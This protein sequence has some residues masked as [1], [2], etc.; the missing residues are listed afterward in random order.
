MSAIKQGIA[1]LQAGLKK[2]EAEI[3]MAADMVGAA[4]GAELMAH[5]AN[6]MAAFHK[7]AAAAVGRTEV[8]LPARC[9]GRASGAHKG[10]PALNSTV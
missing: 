2:A 6:M 4:E 1:E 8:R 10:S 7:S 3:S 5:F 9:T